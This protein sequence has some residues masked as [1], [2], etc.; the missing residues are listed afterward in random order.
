[1]RSARVVEKSYAS[2]ASSQ[3]RLLELRTALPIEGDSRPVIRPVFNFPVTEVDHLP[4][5]T[6]KKSDSDH[7]AKRVIGIG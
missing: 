2:S 3:K 6:R 4:E 7:T 5:H 1:M